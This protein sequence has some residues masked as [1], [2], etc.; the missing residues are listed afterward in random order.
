M[1]SCLK[2]ISI[3]FLLFVFFGCKKDQQTGTPN[4]NPDPTPTPTPVVAEFAKGADVSWITQMEA[5]GQKFYNSTFVQ[6]EGMQL[7]K[8][9]GMNTVRLRVWVNPTDGWNNKADVLTKALRA[10]NL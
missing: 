9:L 6:T 4:P 1:K 7:L 10:K 5:D 2:P 8:S 3:I